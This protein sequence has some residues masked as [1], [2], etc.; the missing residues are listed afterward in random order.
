M[1]NLPLIRPFSPT[2]SKRERVTKRSGSR[3]RQ[4]KKATEAFLRDCTLPAHPGADDVRRFALH[5]AFAQN[6]DHGSRNAEP[7]GPH[8]CNLHTPK[9]QRLQRLL[10][11]ESSVLK[12][13]L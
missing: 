10:R 3:S 5:P 2:F 4:L 7:N 12:R 11:K 8:R 9:K 6:D 1:P 13:W